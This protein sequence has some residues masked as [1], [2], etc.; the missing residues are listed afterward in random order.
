MTVQD[1]TSKAFLYL[2]DIQAF[3]AFGI[4]SETLKQ[5]KAYCTKH[6]EFKYPCKKSEKSK[7]AD[8]SDILYIFRT[9]STFRNMSLYAIPYS[10]VSLV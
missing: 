7:N 2:K 10:K 1:G 8:Y 6:K 5:I 4:S 9:S 3:R